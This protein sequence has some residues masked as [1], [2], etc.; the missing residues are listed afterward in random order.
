MKAILNITRTP[1]HRIVRIGINIA[2]LPGVVVIT[3]NQSVIGSS[4]DNFGVF[5]RRRNPARLTTADIEPVPFGNAVVRG[6]AGDAHG[7]VVLLGSVD[8]VRKI[9]VE[10]D[11][12]ELRRGLILFRPAAAAIERDVGA[13]V[14]AFNHAIRIVGRNPQIVIVA[15]RYTDTREGATPVVRSIKSSVQHVNFVGVL[16]ICVDARVIP[17]ALPQ[18]ALLVGFCPGA[19]AVV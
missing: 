1:A 11:A 12:I 5:R 14:V 8:V 3:S 10:S 9:I 13:A 2:Q 19:S 6:P 4:K 18:I 16:R 15:M 7:R 17:R